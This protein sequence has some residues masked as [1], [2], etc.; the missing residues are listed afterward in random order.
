MLRGFCL[1]LLALSLFVGTPVFAQ[2][3]PSARFNN[4]L[5]VMSNATSF[6]QVKPFFSA[7]AFE[8]AYGSHLDLD[9][10]DQVEVLKS[11][12]EMFAGWTVKSEKIDGNT[13]T[14][15]LASP[16][17]ETTEAILVKENGT[18]LLDG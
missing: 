6:S 15:V 13:A 18:W 10:Q 16:K 12:S 5:S 7:K 14:L 3:S 9:A 17:G 4:Y 1:T 8:E 2:E 11:T